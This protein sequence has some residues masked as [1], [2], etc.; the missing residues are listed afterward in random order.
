[1]E[2]FESCAL[3]VSKQNK[4]IYAGTRSIAIEEGFKE[5]PLDLQGHAQGITFENHVDLCTDFD[6]LD[7]KSNTSL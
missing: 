4:V 5:Q 1:M 6:S 2:M 3:K 7:F